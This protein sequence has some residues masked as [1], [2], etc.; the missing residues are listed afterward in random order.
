MPSAWVASK[1][2]PNF[3]TRQ[4]SSSAF[5][6]S[7]TRNSQTLPSWTV[8]IWVASIAHMILGAFV[9]IWRSCASPPFRR[10][11]WGES[12]A[13]TCLRLRSLP[14]FSMISAG[15]GQRSGT[16]FSRAPRRQTK[17]GA[18]FD[19]AVIHRNL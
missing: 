4:P 16:L 12:R 10:A 18:F 1:R 15:F 8:V 3:A 9:M 13:F 5:Q 19:A 11:L 17:V 2:V 6:C 7:A 14:V